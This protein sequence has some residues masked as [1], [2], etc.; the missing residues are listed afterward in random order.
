MTTLEEKQ[1]ELDA[2][3]TAFDE[4]I[5]SSRELE[6]ELDAEFTKC[7]KDLT[8]AE[9]RNTALASQLANIQPQLNSLETKLSTLTTHLSSETQRRI[10]AEMK[11]EE[12][13]NKLRE[14]EGTLAAVRSSEVRKLKEENEELCERLAFVE[15]EAEDYRNELNTDRERHREEVG[16]LK[17]DVNV[18]KG[19]LKERENELEKLKSDM[20][21]EV[22]GRETGG[23]SESIVDSECATGEEKVSSPPPT[24]ESGT[25]SDDREDY[26]RTLEDELEI[27]TEQLI[28]AETKLSQTQAELEEALVEAEQANNTLEISMINGSSSNGAVDVNNQH[29]NKITELESTINLLQKENSSLQEESKRLKE[30][31]ELAL[32]E[33]ALSKEELE[34]YE[35]DRREQSSEFELERKQHKGEVAA[36]QTKLDKIASEERSR[37]IE[38]KSWEETLMA[39]KKETQ[40][41]QDEVDQLVVALKNSKAD[42]ETLQEEMD[43][44]KVAFDETTNREKVESEGQY[45]ALEE[46]LATRSREVDELKGEVSNLSDTNSSL[47]KMLKDTEDNLNKQRS[48]IEKQQNRVASA[49]SKELEDKQDKIRLLESLLEAARKE[50]DLQQNEV[51]KVRSSLQKKITQTQ[52]ELA[53]AEDELAK[54]QSKLM[55]IEKDRMAIEQ[56]PSSIGNVELKR[57]KKMARLSYSHVPL[58]RSREDSEEDLFPESD[59]Y[60]SHALSRRLYSH[61]SRSRPRSCSPTTIQR[62]EGDAERRAATASSLQVECNWLEDQNRMGVSMKSKLE[63]ELKQLQKQLKIADNGKA[64]SHIKE[65]E[66]TVQDLMNMDDTHIEDML[67]SKDLD[68]IAKEFRLMAK[69]MSALK[70]H[71]AQLLTRI[72]KLQG[73][74]Q[75]CCRIR[76]MSMDESQKGLHEVAQSLSETEI[77]CFDERTRSWKSY[78]FDKVWGPETGQ[79]DVFHDVEP[80]ASS[81][82]D[83]YNACIFA[84]GQTGSGKTYTMEGSKLN[85]QYG[86]S[87]RMIQK[88][89]WLLQDKAQQHQRNIANQD[90]ES[91]S[92][93]FEYKIEVGMLEIYNDEVYDLLD[94]GFS[95]SGIPVGSPKKKALDIRHG[96]DKTVEVP[97][98][99]KE[100]VNTVSE[101]LSA[102]DRGNSNRAKAATNLNEHSSRSHMILQVE[103]TSGVGDGKNKGSLYLVDL[104]GSERVRKSEVEGKALKEAQHINKSL[105]ALGNVMEALDRK[106]SHVP[107]R[108][109][110]LTYLLQNSLGGNS[111][112]M[113]VVTACPHNDSYDETAFAL[114]FATRVRRINLGSAQK[115]ITSKNLEESIKQLTSEL[116]LA[117]KAKERSESQLLSLRREKERVEEKLSKASLSRANSKEEM[118]TLSVLRQTNNDITSRWQKEKIMR[119]EKTVE[120]AKVQEELQRVQRDVR[121][122]KREQE[123][124]AQQNEEKENTIFQLKKDIRSMKE[125]LNEEKIR[126]RRSQVMQSRIPAPTKGTSLRKLVP[127]QKPSGLQKPSPKATNGLGRKSDPNASD[128]LDR[129]KNDPKIAASLSDRKK[130]D[131]NNVARIRYRVLKMLQEHDPAKVDKI[132]IVMAK[133]EGRETELLEKMM[134]RYHE[135]CKEDSR[136]VVSTAD[137]T[138]STATTSSSDGRPKSRQDKALERHMA[139]MKRIKAS[140]DKNDIL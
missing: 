123:S 6:E 137:A 91:P 46:L 53:T 128:V 134:A 32:E 60:R 22:M 77:G 80:M 90:D 130:N 54:T 124:L 14:S 93:Q 68:I 5:V 41:L 45:Q 87:Q 101:V 71:N 59:F 140:A 108:D 2:L 49:S 37:D 27:V 131:P 72:L 132:D 50:L 55:E 39:S 19:K 33:L 25:T 26:I 40:S 29:T 105:S 110:K 28:Q 84:Y 31:L 56:S 65:E 67:Q 78:A 82:I 35:E 18:L 64:P 114:K 103:V 44:L 30:E 36:L 51:Q 20:D 42:Y 138:E 69:K 115:N 73:N 7:Q 79:K 102:L 118:R 99:I 13:E 34:A 66:E 106:A 127:S 58:R 57:K 11:S 21:N 97:G 1:K 104:A 16:E 120:L 129:K 12:A 8:K 10:S 70:S 62:L 122:V 75:V 15:V 61:K 92:P 133:F 85:S 121:N 135:G 113:M 88:L 63:G 81:V 111:R 117:S 109:S 125:Q 126:L 139:R 98:L 112:T 38:V 4:Y 43:A 95:S 86:I 116:S 47:T 89:F 107:Y 9:S 119:E 74:I 136:S 96:A 48:E 94:P 24:A 23:K 100:S 3:Q 76:P 17:G 52:A 83:G